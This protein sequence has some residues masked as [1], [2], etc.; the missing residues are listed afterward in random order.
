M[1]IV[2]KHRIFRQTTAD[3]HD[4][5]RV[6]PGEVGNTQLLNIERRSVAYMAEYLSEDDLERMEQ[7]AATP[8]YE[9][10]PELLVPTDGE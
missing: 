3:Y 2:S 1:L 4:Q 5:Q 6:S 10:D 8:K 7:F 9:R